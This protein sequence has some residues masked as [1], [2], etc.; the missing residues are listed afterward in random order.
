MNFGALPVRLNP[1]TDQTVSPT[2]GHS[3]LVAGLGAGLV[4]LALVLLYTILYYRALGLVIVLG[5]AD[6]GGAAVGHHLGARPY[7]LCAQFRP[8]RRYRDNC[9]HW[10]HGRQLHRVF[11]TIKRR[12]PSRALH[13]LLG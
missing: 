8:G 11:R 12:G 3:A 5:L 6:D 9:V 4:G 10:H 2:L 1:L 13:P 7:R